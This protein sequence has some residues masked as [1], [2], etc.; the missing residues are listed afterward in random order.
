MRIET[1]H[2]YSSKINPG[3]GMVFVR[4][5]CKFFRFCRAKCRRAFNKMNSRKKWSLVYCKVA[6]KELT[7]NPIFEFEKRR[8]VPF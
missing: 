8:N 1:C 7:V 6:G 5:D 4:N 3:Y 2:F